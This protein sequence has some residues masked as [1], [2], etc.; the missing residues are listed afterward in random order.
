[1]WR[2]HLPPK[3]QELAPAQDMNHSKWLSL[4]QASMDT[5][6]QPGDTESHTAHT[7]PG[8]GRLA[9]SLGLC[10]ISGPCAGGC[11]LSSHLPHSVS[12]T[13]PSQ[14]TLE[15]SRTPP[16]LTPRFHGERFLLRPM[17]SALCGAAVSHHVHLHKPVPAPAP[18]TC[19]P[20]YLLVL[21]VSTPAPLQ[22][23]I[24]TE[25]RDTI[26][27]Y[28]LSPF[29]SKSPNDYPTD[30]QTKKNKKGLQGAMM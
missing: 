11:W 17:A 30:L 22:S 13:P 14:F 2:H 25:T 27:S 8:G 7:H 24:H 20:E 21:W 5:R 4:R 9:L 3:S 6:P 19:L 1:M 15:S 28:I 10:A 23:V 12:S 18:L 29:Y 26:K 16:V